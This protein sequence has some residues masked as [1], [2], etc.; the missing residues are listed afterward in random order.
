[1]AVTDDDLEVLVQNPFLPARLDSMLSGA[2]RP[3][4][5]I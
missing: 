5:D 2:P 1:M 4:K 3:I